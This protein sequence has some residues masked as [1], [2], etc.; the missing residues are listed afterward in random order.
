[1]KEREQPQRRTLPQAWQ[2]GAE[3]HGRAGGP[4]FRSS[5]Q[6]GK[7][8]ERGVER[9]TYGALQAILKTLAFPFTE[10]RTL[11]GKSVEGD[12]RS[13]LPFRESLWLVCSD[14]V[15]VG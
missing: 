12:G 1:M 11:R 4:G 10:M 6:E 7:W 5:E 15:G 2:V 8:S 14:S 9:G 3:V 13:D